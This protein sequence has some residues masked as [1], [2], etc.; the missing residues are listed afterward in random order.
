MARSR[1]DRRGEADLLLNLG[2]VYF[3]L[4][5]P[6]EAQ[7]SY[8]EALALAK[9]HHLLDT[10]W[11]IY[12]AWGKLD[13][14][15]HQVRQARGHYQKAIDI[16]EQQRQSLHIES[17][18]KFWQERSLLYKRMMSCC[19]SLDEPWA[20][21]E[22]TERARA[23]Y[24]A[25]L[26][27]QDTIPTDDT[28]ELIRTVLQGL[29]ERTAVVVF[30]VTEAGTAVFIATGQPRENGQGSAAYGWQ[31]APDGH[32]QVKLIN[33]FSQ[34]DLKRLL[35]AE[36]QAD[37]PGGYL[38][39]YHAHRHDMEK[40]K[41]AL[42]DVCARL[43]RPLLMPIHQQLQQ[44]HIKQLVLMP[45]LGLSLLPLHACRLADGDQPYMLDHYE[46]TYAPSFDVLRHCQRKARNTTTQG[47]SLLAVANPTQDLP[48]AE[49]EVEQI[50]PSF[51][52]R[53]LGSS[54]NPATPETVLAEAPQHAVLHFACH[55]EFSLSDPL[56]SNLKLAGGK[57]LRLETILAQLKL[58]ETRLVVLSA[59]ETGL[60]DPG[61]LADE[62]VGLP[63]GFVQAGAPSVVSSL[64]A[65]DDISTALLMIRFYQFYLKG[66]AARGLEPLRPAQAL[67]EAQLW[68]RDA[69]VEGATAD[70]ERLRQKY[71]AEN[72]WYPADKLMSMAKTLASRSAAT[73]DAGPFAHPYYWAA[74]TVVG[75]A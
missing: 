44:L 70:L 25:D 59:C 43:G 71:E 56:Q 23:R 66:D 15:Q 8:T 13:D 5:E 29:P 24:L 60:V 19:L 22:F 26:L 69:T 49:F 39:N 75:A 30:N 33:E 58:P 31:S 2:N 11:R 52:T 41:P 46:I 62:Y 36:K 48:W 40:W 47:A 7:Q 14:E 34:H 64:W 16:V 4:K 72:N 54:T 61:D 28:Q 65:V 17:R 32:I 6:A 74:F 50:A 18:M 9:E 20:A 3:E 1:H 35:F 67:H 57:P 42:Q 12:Y 51:K 10:E 53:I 38:V 21:L 55:G 45:N 63:A 37:Q 27:S 68:L 73:G